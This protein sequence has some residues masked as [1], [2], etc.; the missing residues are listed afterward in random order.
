MLI[1]HKPMWDALMPSSFSEMDPYLEASLR[2]TFHC[3]FG[4]QMMRQLAPKL[5]PRYLVPLADDPLRA[6]G[7]RQA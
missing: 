7:K 3:A 1:H 4:A 2:T 5:R 6:A